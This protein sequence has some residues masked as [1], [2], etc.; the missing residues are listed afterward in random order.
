MISLCCVHAKTPKS[1]PYP[2]T[3]VPSDGLGGPLWVRLPFQVFK[4]LELYTSP[5]G[6]GKGIAGADAIKS[7][8]NRRTGGTAVMVLIPSTILSHRADDHSRKSHPAPTCQ[9]VQP[10]KNLDS[11]KTKVFCRV[12]ATIEG[13]RRT[14][15]TTA[16]C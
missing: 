13:R 4:Y 8:P 11:A 14:G 15:W 10:C 7:R 16:P 12:A 1:S 9:A 5:G 2:R 3:E 6:E